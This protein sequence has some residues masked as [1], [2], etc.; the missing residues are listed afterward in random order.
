MRMKT[1]A[2]TG[3]VIAFAAAA[4]AG[5][6]ARVAAAA[7]APITIGSIEVLSGPVAKYGVPI[8]QG[9]ELAIEEINTKGV[10]SG[11]RLEV[12]FEDSAGEKEQ[13]LNAMKKL[14]ARD[15][16]VAVLGPTLSSEMFAAGPAAVERQTP[17]IGATTTA[18]GVTDI[19][20]WIFR[21]ALP[22]S[23][24]LPVTI[25]AVKKRFGAKRIALMY[26]NDDA[27][28]K[29][30][31]DAMRE[32]AERQGLE[33]VATETFSSKETDF[34]AQLTKIKGL[35]VDAIGISALA[36][37]G[38][39]VVLQAR[40]LGIGPQI[41]LFGGNGFNSP[42][43]AE[44]AGKAA[45]GFMVGTPWFID[46]KDPLNEKFVAA[47]RA[48]YNADPDQF[49]A[50]GY[51]SALILAEAIDRAGSTEGAKLRDALL[52][53]DHAGILGHFQFTPHRDPASADGVVV[54]AVK[55]GKFATLD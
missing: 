37:A 24:V 41:P 43:M 42:K 7:L 23:E 20:E 32:A 28:T 40:Q 38:A 52:K 15:H 44:I 12:V 21:T 35:N 55:N 19:G 33:I 46:K 8:R 11:R 47:Y 5:E 16:V 30:G 49:A 26:S 48:K 3:L 27:F 18:N 10:L 17:V 34:S 51:D 14:L 25:A 22:E 2:A 9:I 29:S 13:A 1:I 6:S 31:F 4:L 50:Q 53:T 54:L 39:G 45:E 36:E